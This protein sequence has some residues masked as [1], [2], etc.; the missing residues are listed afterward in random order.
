ML[1]E[2]LPL[3]Y[4]GGGLRKPANPDDILQ[5]I[6]GYTG[7]F[8]DRKD[9]V[10]K[11]V[12]N[13]VNVILSSGSQTWTMPVSV[14]GLTPTNEGTATVSAAGTTLT[15]GAGTIYDVDVPTVGYYGCGEGDYEPLDISG[16]GND[17][18]AMTTTWGT[19]DSIR[20]RNLADGFRALMQFDLVDVPLAHQFFDPRHVIA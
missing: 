3:F 19:A 15:F 18:S 5:W 1:E 11:P 8:T 6:T 7:T 4:S 20:S 14:A 2:Y 12:A 16:N 17:V 10:D 13:D 9:L